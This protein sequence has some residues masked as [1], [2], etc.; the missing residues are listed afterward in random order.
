MIIIFIR[1]F[2]ILLFFVFS[3]LQKTS[4]NCSQPQ[5]LRQ[6]CNLQVFLIKITIKVTFFFNLLSMRGIKFLLIFLSSLNGFAKEATRIDSFQ[7]YRT[8]NPSSAD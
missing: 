4:Q 8:R 3:L 6:S 5:C 7:S 1:F 2:Q